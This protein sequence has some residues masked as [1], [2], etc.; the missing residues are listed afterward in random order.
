M[1]KLVIIFTLAMLSAAAA[2]MLSLPPQPR[3]PL[4]VTIKL[5]NK[6]TNEPLG[7]ATHD[8]NR[9]YMR[10]KDGVHYATTVINEDGSRTHYDP[11]GKVINKVTK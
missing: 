3:Q 11:N 7:T 6:A 8:G 10:D 4:P 9:I 1:N 5:Y 2:Q